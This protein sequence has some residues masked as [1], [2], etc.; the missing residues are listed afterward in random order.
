[1]KKKI[2]FVFILVS[3]T[4]A[5]KAQFDPSK[6]QVNGNFQIDAQTYQVDEGIQ[7]NDI[8]GKKTGLNGFGNV[9]YR[10]GNFTAGLRYEAYLPPLNGF[11]AEHEGQGIAHRYVKYSGDLLD[12]TVGNFYDQFGNGLIFRS[13]EEWTLGL[14]NAMDG[15]H[16][17]L[18]PYDGITL[19]GVYGTQRH[20]WNEYENQN[21][22][23]VRG[24]D[25]E[26]NVNLLVES[27]VSSKTRIILGGSFVSKYEKDN[28]FS[29]YKLPE[30]VGA[31]AGRLNLRHGKW[32][33]QSEYAYKINDPNSRNNYIFKNGEAFWLSANYSQRG[34]GVIVSAK[35]I[36]NF[37][38]SSMRS[39]SVGKAPD[40]NF[41][42]PL[43]YQHAYTLPAMYPYNTQ[44]NGEM[45][46]S[47]EVFYT[48]PRK[49]T[50]GGKYGTRLSLNYSLIHGID[51]Q[52]L[53]GD[54]TLSKPGTDGYVSDFFKVGDIKHYR[55]FSVQIDKKVNSDLKFVAGYT[56]LDYNVEVVEEEI[57][58]GNRFY[59]MHTGLLDVT[60]KLDT[61]KAIRVELQ[62]LSME[63]DSGNWAMALAEYS[64][65]PNW[66]FT[67]QDQYNFNNP[68][69]NNTYHYY[70]F[71]VAYAR[72]ATRI[73]VS[74]GR[75]RE[76]II[77][78]GGICRQVPASSGLNL[79]ITSSF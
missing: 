45:G 26:V 13:Y 37:S 47:G 57:A 78:V 17:R 27:L 50:L 48:I 62:Y 12:I 74:Y 28:P 76:G 40:I 19:K 35:R 4:A 59:K 54:S 65:S 79:T 60:Y 36:D 30:N 44:P 31:Y 51:R 20:Y 10:Y 25:A 52:P 5:A 43:A 58:Q 18:K 70:T 2:L 53:P 7:L 11:D 1:M 64:I 73:S 46:V 63:Q 29:D 67:V 8:N 61:K 38:F 9:T 3:F 75:Q 16:I 15:V 55:D 39:P 32:S 23:I 49:T 24:V 68:K 41:L 77:C 72:K 22:G 21:R 71:G 69:S 56:W 34:L 6:A 14:D 42:P 33:L 66:F